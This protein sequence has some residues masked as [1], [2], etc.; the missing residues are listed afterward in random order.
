MTITYSTLSFELQEGIGHLQFN[1]PPSNE[2][3]LAFFSELHEVTDRMRS[4]NDIKALVISGKGRH[5]SSGARL[6]ELLALA[7][8]EASGKPGS[9][10]QK[11]LHENNRSFL[12]FESLRIPVISAIRG[13]CLGSAMEI[14]FFCHF[15]FCGEDAVFGLPETT[16]NLIPGIG[17]ISRIFSLSGAATALEVV[18]RGNTFSAEEAL[19]LNLVDL[20]LPKKE[21]VKMAIEFV[22]HLPFDYRKE[23]S[24]LYIHRFATKNLVT[25]ESVR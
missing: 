15:R 20:I 4:L 3:T 25:P 22:R 21:V 5:F 11:F 12:F 19:K 10:M 13:A 16:F 24:S 1:Q 23:K 8:D 14:A 2:M 9:L 7:G 17:G 6:T 18:L